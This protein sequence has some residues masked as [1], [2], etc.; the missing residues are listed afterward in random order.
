MRHT[1][2]A[3]HNVDR[4]DVGAGLREL[5]ACGYTDPCTK[6]VIEH[7]LMRWMRGEEEQAERG[8]IDADFH[9][10]NFTSWRR[11]LSAARYAAEQYTG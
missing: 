8:A 1:L 7:A 11:V 10:I 4:I 5:E 6:I 3:G 2:I 9:G